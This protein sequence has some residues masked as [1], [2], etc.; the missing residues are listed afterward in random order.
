MDSDGCAS[1]KSALTSAVW[2]EYLVIFRICTLF[3][4]EKKLNSPPGHF[5][6]YGVWLWP[7]GRHFLSWY[8]MSEDWVS[9]RGLI[10]ASAS[11][12]SL[13]IL[14]VCL[15]L[16]YLDSLHQ[17]Y[18]V[19]PGADPIPTSLATT[20]CLIKSLFTSIPGSRGPDIVPILWQKELV[21]PLAN[22]KLRLCIKLDNGIVKPRPP[23]ARVLRKRWMHWNPPAT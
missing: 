8:Y 11:F 18:L 5:K 9:A 6:N 7:R 15:A 19:P 14:K 10:L 12:F 23:V 17:H 13:H 1:L 20:E 3:V 4:E 22:R 2:S 16:T 21:S